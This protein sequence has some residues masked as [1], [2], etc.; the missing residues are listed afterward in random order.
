M[1]REKE[2]K[3]IMWHFLVRLENMKKWGAAHS[4]LKRVIKSLPSQFIASAKGKKL[5][6]KAIKNLVNLGFIGIYKKAGADHTSLNPR[7]AGEI[8]EFIKEVTKS[9]RGNAYVR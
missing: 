2:V 8:K 4:E 3:V 6:K 9:M 7:K 1:A 5:I